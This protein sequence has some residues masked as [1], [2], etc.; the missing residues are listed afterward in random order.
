MTR[1][2]P[3]PERRIELDGFWPSGATIRSR[4]VPDPA[5]DVTFA[6]FRCGYPGCGAHAGWVSVQTQ[7]TLVGWWEIVIVGPSPV[8]PVRRMVNPKRD[9]ISPPFDV[10][11]QNSV[12]HSVEHPGVARSGATPLVSY[13]HVCR[14]CWRR[15]KV[16]WLR[17]K[18]AHADFRLYQKT[19]VVRLEPAP[20]PSAED[21]QS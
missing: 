4:T 7:S 20:W 1:R 18:R 15:Y 11:P 17:I 21:N 10:D 5:G 2:K 16:D 6:T 14:K 12:S 8:G 19:Q 13:T 3:R 9:P